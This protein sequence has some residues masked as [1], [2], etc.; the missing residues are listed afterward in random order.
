MTNTY[1]ITRDGAEAYRYQCDGDPLTFEEYP[2]PPFTQEL[3]PPVPVLVY[4]GRRR[5]SRYEFLSLYTPQER[6][7]IRGSTNP[8]VVD[9]QEMLGMALEV[10]LDNPATQQSVGY[11]AAAGLL[12]PTRAA[13]ILRG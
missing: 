10:D 13:E 3:V 8:V 5:L 2:V 11:L 9:I 6:I 12:Q 1:S 4:D 7:A